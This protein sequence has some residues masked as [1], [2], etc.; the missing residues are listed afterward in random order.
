MSALAFTYPH[1]TN[2]ELFAE[3][4]SD[5]F[6]DETDLCANH[7]VLMEHLWSSYLMDELLQRMVRS[8]EMV[9]L[10]F[11]RMLFLDE[12][13]R[14]VNGTLHRHDLAIAAYVYALLRLNRPDVQKACYHYLKHSPHSGWTHAFLFEL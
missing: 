3:I 5:R 11:Q 2:H 10:V 12:K 6:R 14:P 1:W 4:E 13:D 8:Q 7:R 9:K